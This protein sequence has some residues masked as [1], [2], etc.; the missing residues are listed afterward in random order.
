MD[1]RLGTSAHNFIS[2]GQIG[3][4]TSWQPQTSPMYMWYRYAN[5]WLLFLHGEAKIGVNSQGG[6]RGVTK[7]ESQNWLMPMAFKGVGP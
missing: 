7:F 3:S 1:I 2:M 5:G 6:P 4:G